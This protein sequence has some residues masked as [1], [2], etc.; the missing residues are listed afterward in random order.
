MTKP[1][2]VG[3]VGTGYLGRFHAEKYA[4]M[5][6]DGVTLVGVA[7]L[8]ISRAEEVVAKAG[9]GARAF[10]TADELIAAGV[11][12]VSVVV[13]THV[14]HAVT[15]PILERGIDCLV[16]KPFAVTLEEADELI[17][18]AK[19]KNCVLQVGHLERF[20]P[21]MLGLKD[22]IHNP[23]FVESH[24]LAPFGERGTEVDVILDLMIHDLDIILMAVQSEVE[25]VSAVGIPVLTE[26]IDIANARLEFANGC[27]ANVTAS[28]VSGSRMRKIRLFQADA[29]L[30]IDYQQK[31]VTIVRRTTGAD[32]KPEVGG[33]LLE[34]KEGDAL[35]AELKSFVNAVRTRGTPEVTGQDGRKALSLAHDIGEAIRKRAEKNRGRVPSA[36]ID[37]IVKRR[38][39]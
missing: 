27:V 2:R 21:V 1:V 26:K 36:L 37:S 7:D 3:V 20:N 30:S 12:A 6:A 19:K 25:S 24:R 22:K 18:L 9:G 28:R 5:H 38:E 16:E 35:E 4:G 14:H 17:A 8:E 31:N 34:I 23:M 39:P 10:R 33:E 15:M 11:D 13:P 29:Y 32:G